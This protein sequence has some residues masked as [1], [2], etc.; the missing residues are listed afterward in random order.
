MSLFDSP[1]KDSVFKHVEQTTEQQLNSTKPR[2]FEAWSQIR[3]EIGSRYH[4]PKVQTQML[5]DRNLLG[6][7]FYA[8]SKKDAWK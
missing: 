6:A 5:R 3:R 4:T 7:N 1:Q 8:S 2:N